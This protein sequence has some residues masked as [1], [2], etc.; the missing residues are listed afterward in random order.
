[1][2]AALPVPS[3]LRLLEVKL[4]AL[5]LQLDQLVDLRTRLDALLQARKGDNGRIEL[6][7]ELGAGFSVEGVVEDT[8]KIICAAGLDDLFLELP[9]EEARDF[10]AKRIAIVEK[11]RQAVEEPLTRMQEEYAQLASTLQ[12]A[13]QAQGLG[14]D[15]PAALAA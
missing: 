14:Q 12:K 9:V 8:S 3:E 10:V 11:K 13:L 15:A 6:P 1:M 5:S 4:D 2:Q 7:V